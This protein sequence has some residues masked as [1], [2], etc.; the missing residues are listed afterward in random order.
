MSIL[1]VALG[2]FLGGAG[3]LFLSRRL[4]A[5]WGTWTANMIAC[6]ILGA[7]TSLLHSPLGLALVATGGAGALSTWSTL[8]RELGQLA[9]DGRRKAAGIYLVASVVGGATCVVVGLSL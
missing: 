5:F 9:Q 1:A 3:R 6:L 2:G 8:V 4:P 7:T